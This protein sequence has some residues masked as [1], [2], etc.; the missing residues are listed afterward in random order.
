VILSSASTDL[1]TAINE[2]LAAWNENPKTVRLDCHGRFHR[3]QTGPLPPNPRTDPARLHHSKTPQT[4]VQLI[5]GQLSVRF[6]MA[7]ARVPAT[8][9]G[10]AQTCTP[11]LG[12]MTL[13][14]CKPYG[15]LWMASAS[16]FFRSDKAVGESRVRSEPTISGAL[17]IAH[18]PMWMR[19]IASV[20]PRILMTIMS[21]SL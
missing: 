5:R 19:S 9:I 12:S 11:G 21:K 8:T 4:F 20:M 10:F 15:S 7:T 13:M 18:S 3:R 2:F 1:I 16:L 6:S 14:G 17:E